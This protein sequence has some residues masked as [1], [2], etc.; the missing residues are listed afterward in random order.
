MP[1]SEIAL[2]KQQIEVEQIAAKRGLDGL[3]I[4]ARHQVITQRME[5]MWDKFQG[6]VDQVGQEEA[7]RL[8]FGESLPG[9]EVQR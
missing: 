6:L 8:T 7:H 9:S 5:R 2:I 3:A 4:V 1:A